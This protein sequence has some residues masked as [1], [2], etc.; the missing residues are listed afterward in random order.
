MKIGLIDY[1][2]D[3][4]HANNY[5][6]WIELAAEKL[7]VEA[8]IAHVWAEEPAPEGKLSTQEWCTRFGGE[9]CDTLEE[10]CE[11]SDV[12]MILAPSNPEKHLPYA[13]RALKYG[14]P[15]YIDKTFAPDAATARR[16]YEL[17]HKYG[18]SIFSTSAL[19][20]AE[21]MNGFE[22][23]HSV[24]TTGGGRLL[25]EYCIHQIEMIVRL[26]GEDA[27]SVICGGNEK[28]ATCLIDF[29][30]GRTATLHY[31]AQMPFTLDIQRAAGE[32]SAYMPV[33]SAYFPMLLEKIVGFY[34]G[35][36]VP[37]SEAQTMACMSLRDAVLKA[38]REPGRRMAV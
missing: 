9:A 24:S 27:K 14:K 34:A 4:W 5:P 36:P 17:A 8:E 6:A 10:V 28:H 19:R 38:A 13:E 11:K 23:V 32:E 16:I 7:G 22:R 1:M 20:Y 35:A 25:E 29:G 2:I 26:M 21:E 12:I 31:G 30:H 37:V 18:A 33:D 3:E 15:T